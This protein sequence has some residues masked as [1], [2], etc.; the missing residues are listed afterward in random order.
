MF[1][2]INIF[3]NLIST[4]NFILYPYYNGKINF[5][6]PM[7]DISISHPKNKLAFASLHPGTCGIPHFRFSFRQITPFYK[8][9]RNWF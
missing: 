5:I 4:Y 1:V 3:S 2:H 8:S 9:F 7:D 6:I